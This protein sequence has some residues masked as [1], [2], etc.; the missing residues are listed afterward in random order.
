MII[1]WAGSNLLMFGQF[2]GSDRGS[3]VNNGGGGS[4]GLIKGVF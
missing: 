3:Q 2:R 4:V 1:S